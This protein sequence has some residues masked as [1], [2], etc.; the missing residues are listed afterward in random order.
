MRE[1]MTR[2]RERRGGQVE[3][4]L[5]LV[6]S[7]SLPTPQPHF[8]PSSHHTR[9]QYFS[10]ELHTLLKTYQHELGTE[11][12]NQPSQTQRPNSQNLKEMPS[13]VTV[14]YHMSY[15]NKTID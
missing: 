8:K 5:T 1:E 7:L 9:V 11:R 10:F 2:N 4:K 14:L 3:F 6:F 12:H 15:S 13:D